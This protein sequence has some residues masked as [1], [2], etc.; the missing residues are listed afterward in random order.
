[1]CVCVCDYHLITSR[2]ASDLF[3]T[4][5]LYLNIT[6]SLFLCYDKIFFLKNNFGSGSVNNNNM[7]KQTNG[8]FA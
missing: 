6:K 5:R 1:V 2:D 4:N 8:I 3:T 7:L